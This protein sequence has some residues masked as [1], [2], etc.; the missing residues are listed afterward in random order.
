MNSM[1]TPQKPSGGRRDLYLIFGFLVA[2]VATSTALYWAATS[3]RVDL[4]KLLGTKNN[5]E[6]IAPPRYFAELPLLNQSGI[7]FEFAKE[8]SQWTL[9]IP[10]AGH[11]D[12]GCAHTLYITRQIQVAL[13][14]DAS[15]VRRYLIGSEAT[16]DA[17]FEKLLT[18]HP[19]VKFL[20]AD[21]ATYQKLFEGF[22]PV[23]NQQYFIVDPKGWLMMVYSPALDGNAVMADL[24]F[25]LKNSHENE[26]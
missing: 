2:V 13:G 4:P 20:Q 15:R 25:L 24:K 26:G 14:K 21:A 22:E 7:A 11:C 18:Q 19:G 9:L 1:Q 5:G 16:P 6:L 17:A 23:R 3:G 8:S 12:E 10:V